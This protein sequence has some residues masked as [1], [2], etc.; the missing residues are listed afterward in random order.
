MQS[1]TAAAGEIREY[2]GPTHSRG[3]MG[4]FVRRAAVE[5]ASHSI[6]NPAGSNSFRGLAELALI[7]ENLCRNKPN[8]GKFSEC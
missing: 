3:G 4:D 2:E 8:F 1:S 5:T 7:D 6:G